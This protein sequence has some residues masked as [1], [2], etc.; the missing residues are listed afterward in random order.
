[1]GKSKCQQRRDSLAL[2]V[3][4]GASI[5]FFRKLKPFL[6]FTNLRRRLNQGMQLKQ[7]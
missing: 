7:L 5:W 2:E 4:N 6:Y 1:M 3:G